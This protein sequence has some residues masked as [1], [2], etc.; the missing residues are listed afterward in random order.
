MNWSSSFHGLIKSVQYNPL[1]LV[2]L[3]SG[4]RGEDGTGAAP[5]LENVYVV[6]L[7]VLVSPL[8]FVVVAYSVSRLVLLCAI[9]ANM[10]QDA[11]SK[12]LRD[13][14]LKSMVWFSLFSFPILASR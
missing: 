8:I 4:C 7:L 2:P 10:H 6:T 1:K 14:L 11:V 3:F 13:I 5:I 9:R 12:S